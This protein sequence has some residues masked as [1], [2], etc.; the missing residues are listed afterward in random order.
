MPKGFRDYMKAS[1][2]LDG[3]WKVCCHLDKL[4]P[5][6][7]DPVDF[8]RQNIDKKLTMRYITLKEEIEQKK[9]ELAELE[10][11]HPQVYA[12]YMIKK[13]KAKARARAKMNKKK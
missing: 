3:I 12:K 9:L 13:E 4:E 8:I 5:K 10:E 6:P 7:D 1:G 11:K 2:G